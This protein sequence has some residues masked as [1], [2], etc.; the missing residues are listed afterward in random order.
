MSNFITNSAANSL[1]KRLIKNGIKE[2]KCESC[3]LFEWNEKPIPIELNHINGINNDNRIE[4]I[5]LL[6]PN[7]H[8]Q[9]PN[10]RG[11]NKLSALSEKREVEFLKFRETLTDNADGNPEPSPKLREGA[12]TKQGKS[13][14]KILDMIKR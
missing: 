4:N 3:G 6:C 14:S 7:C 2:H 11:K 10:Y 13:K 5:Q 12:E 8:A 1:K 9:T